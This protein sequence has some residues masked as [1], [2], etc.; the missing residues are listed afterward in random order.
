M[1]YSIWADSSGPVAISNSSFVLNGFA[2]RATKAPCTITNS[3]FSNSTSQDL[4]LGGVG[5]VYSSTF[6]AGGLGSI[7]AAS[8]ITIRDCLFSSVNGVV[9]N[10]EN[11]NYANLERV[12]VFNSGISDGS[13][14]YV[15]V[16]GRAN[17]SC[18]D[19]EF[20]GNSGLAFCLIIS[21]VFEQVESI[22]ELE[23]K[24]SSTIVH[25]GRIMGIV[26]AELY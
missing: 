11:P 13:Y 8:N 1:D 12:Q 20:G 4:W 23:L 19:C 24:A 17:L 15:Y 18:F 22:L 25:G 14:E 10:F 21:N 9:L 7:V 16:G 6:T 3:S 26:L 5:A 2:V